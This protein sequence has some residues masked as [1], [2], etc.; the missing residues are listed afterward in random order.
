MS[1]YVFYQANKW[2]RKRKR[3]RYKGKRKQEYHN[4]SSDEEFFPAAEPD[5]SDNSEESAQ[6]QS[7]PAYQAI[8][9]SSPA[10]M[11]HGS[12]AQVYQTI[13]HSPIASQAIN[14]YPEHSDHHP[15]QM[16]KIT[17]TTANQKKVT[18]ELWCPRCHKQ[19]HFQ[20]NCEESTRGSLQ[21]LRNWTDKDYD[22]K[23]DM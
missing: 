19:G 22:W 3:L 1:K 9:F 8:D 2:R 5:D 15:Q 17:T 21:G 23:M 12:P 6:S 4:N 14:N 7:S 13:S 20:E 11:A 16:N 18:F 10:F